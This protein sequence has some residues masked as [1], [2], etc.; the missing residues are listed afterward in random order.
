[1]TTYRW[2]LLETVDSFK[3]MGIGSIGIWRPKL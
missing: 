3:R 2:S 1:M